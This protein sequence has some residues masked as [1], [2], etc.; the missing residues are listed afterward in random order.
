MQEEPHHR[1][2]A[3]KPFEEKARSNCVF[4]FLKDNGI[5]YRELD[6]TVEKDEKAVAKWEAIVELESGQVVML[7]CQYCVTSVL[8]SILLT[9]PT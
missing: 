2:V 7:E 8:Y 3:D 1:Q 6:R 9:Y 4:K 5:K